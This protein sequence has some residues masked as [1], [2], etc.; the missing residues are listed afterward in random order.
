MPLFLAFLGVLLV[1]CGLNNTVDDLV[2][3]TL[4]AKDGNGRRSGGDLPA[5]VPWFI[6]IMIVGSVGY[7]KRLQ[8]LAI[9]FMVLI[10]VMLLLSKEGFVQ[11]F[12]QSLGLGSD[13]SIPSEDI[14]YSEEQRGDMD[15]LFDF[16]GGVGGMPD[17]LSAIDWNLNLPSSIDVFG[18]NGPTLI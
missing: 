2:D 7:V 8:P 4:G 17:F 6:A 9:S 11:K 14:G 5:F 18:D 15:S 12:T 1:A 3:L 10:A 16:I 13:G